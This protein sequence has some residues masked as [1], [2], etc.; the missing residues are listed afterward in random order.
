[1]DKLQK[2]IKD[3]LQSHTNTLK[4][5]E[6]ERSSHKQTVDKLSGLETQMKQQDP[7]DAKKFLFKKKDEKPSKKEEKM[8][9]SGSNTPSPRTSLV[10]KEEPKV[11]IFL[12]F[13]HLFFSQMKWEEETRFLS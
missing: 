5:L 6:E 8:K 4:E 2:R 3:L 10:P 11:N 9:T 1:M 12:I 7:K 13:S